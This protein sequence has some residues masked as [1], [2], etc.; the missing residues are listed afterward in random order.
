M[1][2][3]EKSLAEKAQLT[4][5]NFMKSGSYLYLQSYLIERWNTLNAYHTYPNMI[6]PLKIN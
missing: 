3:F 2:D 5:D 4:P 6:K 1:F